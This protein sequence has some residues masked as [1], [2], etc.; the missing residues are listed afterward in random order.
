MSGD[1][2]ASSYHPQPFQKPEGFMV[3][4]PRVKLWFAAANP[5]QRRI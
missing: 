2:K 4:A 5:R 1:E 3:K